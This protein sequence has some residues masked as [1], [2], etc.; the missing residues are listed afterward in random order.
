MPKLFMN[1]SP[2]TVVDAKLTLLEGA[3]IQKVPVELQ[4]GCR[5]NIRLYR[6][7]EEAIECEGERIE[8][9]GGRATVTTGTEIMIV[10]GCCGFGDRDALLEPKGNLL[11]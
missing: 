11:Y 8:T 4:K 6:V 10:G 7:F 1:E 9:A 3:I 2:K 5:Q